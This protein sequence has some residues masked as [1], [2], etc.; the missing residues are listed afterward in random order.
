MSLASRAGAIVMLLPSQ[1][2]ATLVYHSASPTPV[3]IWHG[4]DDGLTLRLSDAIEASV[5]HS[6]DFVLSS[7]K[8]PGTFIITIPTNVTWKQT[9][10]RTQ[11]L[12]SVVIQTADGSTSTFNGKCFESRL[13]DCAAAVINE[14]RK[15]R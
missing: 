11:V 12:Y 6:H 8:V 3:E 1:A 10:V 5:R 7:G 13:N 14:A 2:C 4:G 9:G 15:L